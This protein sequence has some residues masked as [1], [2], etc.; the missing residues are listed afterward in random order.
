MERI[1]Y[2]GIKDHVRSWLKSDE[3]RYCLYQAFA[4]RN[5]AEFNKWILQYHSPNILEFEN[6]GN[7]Y[8]EKIIYEIQN[9]DSNLG[10]FGLWKQTLHRIGY[11]ESLGLLPVVNWGT[12]TPYYDKEK[13][14][15]C[16]EYY[17][18]PVSSVAVNEVS[19]CKN[20]VEAKGWQQQKNFEDKGY[21]LEEQKLKRYIELQKKYIHI[22]KNMREEIENEIKQVI[23]NKKTIAVHIRGVEWGNIANHPVPIGLDKYTDLIDKAIAENNFE[24]VF[25]ASDSED[26]LNA[27]KEKYRDCIVCF[28]DVVRAKAGSHTLA[29]FDSDN[30]MPSAHYL[31]GREVL[32][33]MLALSKCQGLIAGYS[34]IS[35]AAIVWKNADEERNYEYC[36]IM[37]NKINRTGVSVEEAVKK[38]KG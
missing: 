7:L 3:K 16:F 30:D 35:L 17:F 24:Q 4:R 25:V 32:R 29:I 33:D 20:V 8:P 38:M 27:M 6:R 22:K 34:N 26:T 21:V 18:E 1:N 11:A 19:E 10:F 31:M 23:G 28:D 37:Q 5:D 15:N 13:G 14:D 12:K 9:N 36:Q 2:M